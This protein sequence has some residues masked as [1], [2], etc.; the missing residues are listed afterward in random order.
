MKV[1]ISVGT[2][3]KQMETDAAKLVDDLKATDN[4]NLKL[5]FVPLPE[6]DHLTILH[7]SAYKGLLLQN[8]K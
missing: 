5:D 2:E 6:E 7:N 1:Y 4:K 3:G 8:K